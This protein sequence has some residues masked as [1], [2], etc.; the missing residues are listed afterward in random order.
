MDRVT[1]GD[2]AQR[3]GVSKATVSAVINGYATVKHEVRERVLEAME[4]LDFPFDHSARELRLR[5][6][7]NPKRM[8]CIG[9]VIRK[10]DNPFYGEVMQGVQSYANEHDYTLLVSSSEGKPAA[11]QKI[12]STYRAHD[13][14][15]MILAP[16]VAEA[17]DHDHLHELVEHGYP[18]VLLEAVP[19]LHTNLININHET[20]AAAAVRHLIDLGHERIVHFAGPVYTSHSQQRIRG[21][22]RALAEA[23]LP[24][25]DDSIVHVGAQ[26]QESYEI[27]R[28]YFSTCP[29]AERPT[30]VTC[31]NDL[32]ALGLHRALLELGLR[33]PDDV[34]VIGYDDIDMMAYLPVPLST[35]RSPNRQL[36]YRAAELLIRRIEAGSSFPPQHIVLEAALMQR[37]TTASPPTPA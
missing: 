36:G 10:M 24:V 6:L 29:P 12:I 9:L 22:R 34:S 11:E 2:V 19:S 7:R 16:I 21:F 4:A 28:G 25:S 30:A 18:V 37:A 31:F 3:A 17:E 32:V 33:V 8:N 26:L 35:I 20:A 14:D 1:I 27:A 15:G 5:H 23:S 13:V